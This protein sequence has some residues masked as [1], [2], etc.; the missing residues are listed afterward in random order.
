MMS[1]TK[2]S[3]KWHM[4]LRLRLTGQMALKAQTATFEH[5]IKCMLCY[6]SVKIIM[7]LCLFFNGTLKQA[8]RCIY[9]RQR[10]CGQGS[11]SCQD[12]FVELIEAT[13]NHPILRCI[14]IIISLFFNK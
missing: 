3:T 5:Q 10:P 1:I 12:N 9:Q 11:Q 2:N 4:S 7:T 8:I 6:I 13:P 14:I